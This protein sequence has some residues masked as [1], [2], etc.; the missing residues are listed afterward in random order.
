MTL[1]Q[2][3]IFV[4]VAEREHVTRAASDL[5][6]TQSA[7][8][9]AIAALEHRHDVKLFDRVGRRIALTDAGRMFLL[10][11][12]AILARAAA[13][14]QI[15]SDLAGL[16]RGRLSFAASQTVGN[17]WLPP[18]LA[19]FRKRHPGIETP[20]VIGNTETV[21]AAIH[22]GLADIG[23]VEGEVD[24]PHLTHEVVAADAMSIVVAP[25][26]PWSAR[27]A[28]TPDEFGETSWVLREP[29]SG[30]RQLLETVLRQ[31]GRTLAGLDIALELPANE[32]VRAAV[33]AGAGAS[34]MSRLVVATA[35]RSGILVE[36]PAEIPPR[37]FLML[38]HKECYVGR[39]AQAF[40]ALLNEK[41]LAK[42]EQPEL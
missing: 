12:R 6:L 30:T 22:D 16:K 5:N 23:I 35:L 9:A 33:E 10:E 41:T 19:A 8:S 39:A 36:I 4:A 24:D 17:Y 42:R 26:H 7:T 2:L 14:E 28:V 3:R 37:R 20:L 32:A 11:A 15:L 27:D 13:G 25:E 21:A 31:A 29:G 38:H 18:K 40:R 1:E 34:L